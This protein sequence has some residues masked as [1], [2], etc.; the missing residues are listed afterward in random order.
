MSNLD[1]LKNAREV[2]AHY[3]E[4]RNE[5]VADESALA[6]LDEVIAEFENGV[7]QDHI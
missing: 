6:G 1:K 3:V 4:W 5:L 2:L 7:I